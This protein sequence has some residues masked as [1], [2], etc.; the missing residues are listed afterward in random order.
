[1]AVDY[2]TAVTTSVAFPPEPNFAAWPLNL[3]ALNPLIEGDILLV[4]GVPV[5]VPGFYQLFAG[6]SFSLTKMVVQTA[7]LSLLG[8][9][10]KN[11]A[12]LSFLG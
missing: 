7:G 6:L 9:L 4:C 5:G 3:C 11:L 1:M 12:A 8:H 10:L 2:S